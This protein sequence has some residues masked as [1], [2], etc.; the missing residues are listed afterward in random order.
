[1]HESG[2]SFTTFRYRDA[3]YRISPD[4][5]SPYGPILYRIITSEITAL[6]D[7]LEA[8]IKLQPEFLKSLVPLD[9]L[10]GAPTSALIMAEAARKTGIGPMAAVAGT[11]AQLAASRAAEEFSLQSGEIT[12]EIIIENGG[13]IFILPSDKHDGKP[14]IAGIFSGPGSRFGNLAL[15]VKPPPGGIAVCSSSSLLGHSLSFGHC[16]LCTVISADAAAADAAA[17]LGCNLVKT[18]KDLEPAAKHIAAVEKIEGVLI[19]KNDKLAMAGKT[20][21]I[22]RHS[23]RAEFKK[24]TGTFLQ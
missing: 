24:I 19:I 5:K 13:D 7:E 23:D 2:R 21:E 11:V 20:P 4:E 14:V 12:P 18:E 3:S 15:K 6:R 8:Y 1:M 22:V 17:T 9:L 16:D 10:P